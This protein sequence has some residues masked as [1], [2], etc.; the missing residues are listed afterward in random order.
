M[1]NYT[2]VDRVADLI[3]IDL[4]GSSVPT[5]TTVE[6]WIEEI[7]AR[8]DSLGLGTYSVTDQYI[9]VPYSLTTISPSEWF[10]DMETDILRYSQR[11]ALIV[12]LANVKNPIISITSL[13]KNDEDLTDTPSWEEFVEGPGDDSDFILLRSGRGNH[14]YAL[15]IYDDEPSSGPKRLKMTYTWGYNID[16]DILADYPAYR[17][18]RIYSVRPRKELEHRHS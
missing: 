1:G 11:D 14:G 2:S 17:S 10:Y 8:I 7:E 5:S 9:D 3:Q 15:Y 12:P 18:R 16:S 13:Y 4:D 6:R